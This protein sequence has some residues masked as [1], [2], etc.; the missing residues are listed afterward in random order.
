MCVAVNDNDIILMLS[1]I[2]LGMDGFFYI[3]AFTQG[4]GTTSNATFAS[5][6]KRAAKKKA[7]DYAKENPDQ[8]AD[9]AS[10][11]AQYAVDNPDATATFVRGNIGS[12][13]V[14]KGSA[15]M[16]D[17]ADDTWGGGGNQ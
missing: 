6:A 17:A 9:F 8:M 5:A 2:L 14:E 11:A 15:S 16:W 4:V 7:I 10:D 1:F 3:G 13:D 12:D